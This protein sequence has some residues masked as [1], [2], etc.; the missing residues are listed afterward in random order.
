[1]G[2]KSFNKFGIFGDRQRSNDFLNSQSDKPLVPKRQSDPIQKEQIRSK[3]K[4]LNDNKDKLSTNSKKWLERL[5]ISFLVQEGRF[6]HRQKD[7]LNQ[8]HS[9][10][11][12]SSAKKV[13]SKK[14]TSIHLSSEK[15]SIIQKK[16]G[17]C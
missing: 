14:S 16:L 6:S 9:C 12:N 3:L 7:T 15:L 8:I 2:K 11:V 13:I 5:Q 10:F 1:M 17:I 4:F